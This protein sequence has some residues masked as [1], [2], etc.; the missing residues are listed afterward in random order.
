MKIGINARHLQNI[1]SGIV[2]YLLN[3]ILN[4]KKIDDEN[5]Y[6]LFFGSKKNIPQ[7]IL[8]FEFN[9]DI[10]KIPADSQL[11]KILWAH[12][13]L[14]HAISK[15]KI[16]IF[17]ETTFVA[18]LFK[19]CPVVLTIYDLAYLYLPFCFAC[20]QRLYFKSLISQSIRQSDLIIAISENT[21][22][23]IINNF[24]VSPNKIRVIYGGVD[25]IFRPMVDKKEIEKIKKIYKIKKDFVLAVS[26]ISPRKNIIRLIKAFKLLR[27]QKK[28]NIQLVIVGRNGW[29]YR[30]V[31][32]EAVSSG[33]EDDIIFCGHIPKKH[34]LFLYN[35]ASVFAYPSLYEGF[36]LPILE[37][38]ASGC[39]VVSSNTSSMPEVCGDAALLA[40]P[41]NVEE[42]SELLY[43]LFSDE[44]LK[45][46]LIEKGLGRVK[47]FSW[48]KTAKETLIAYNEA[49]RYNRLI[50]A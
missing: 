23:D 40:D 46:N 22:K 35:A 34:L 36:G 13:Y 25:E 28:I 2:I 43:K 45:N 32:R 10:P 19:K 31:F 17:H 15:H 29:L 21:K 20:R 14:P 26:L 7:N 5:E 18:P 37:A 44:S 30:D 9:Y 48:E 11:L 16:D 41:K 27:N 50:K 39:P 3:L 38:M 49:I 12:L 4:L 1:H 42:L 33:L 8:N 47:E 24:S 6:T